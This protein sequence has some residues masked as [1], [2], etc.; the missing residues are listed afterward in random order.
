[1][2]VRPVARGPGLGKALLERLLEEAHQ[3]G[4]E[5]VLLDSAR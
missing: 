3:I 5:R 4:Y 1:M 2:Y